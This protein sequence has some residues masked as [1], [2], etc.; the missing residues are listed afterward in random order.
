[1]ALTLIK[2]GILVDG[3]SDEPNGPIHVL[4]E[5]DRIR[6]VSTTPI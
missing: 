6:E 4:V 5:G 2:N 1:M 3:T